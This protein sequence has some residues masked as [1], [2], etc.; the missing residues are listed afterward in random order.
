[1]HAIKPKGFV[2]DPASVPAQAPHGPVN[3]VWVIL[4]VHLD[5]RI[6]ERL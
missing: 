4:D 3:G 1:M 5:D 6:S 2:G